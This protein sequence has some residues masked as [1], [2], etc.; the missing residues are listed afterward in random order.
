M[1]IQGRIP[2]GDRDGL[3]ALEPAVTKN[4]SS[5]VAIVILDPKRIDEDVDTGHREAVMRIRSIEALLPDDIDA[6]L[7]LLRRAYEHRTGAV[8]LPIDLEDELRDVFNS[9]NLDT[10]EV[11]EKDDADANDEEGDE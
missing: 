2:T 5:L 10:G 11:V 3:T 6:A 4:R 1:K 9:V 8:T 7:R